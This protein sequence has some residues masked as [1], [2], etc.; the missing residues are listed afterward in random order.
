MLLMRELCRD[1]LPTI[2]MWRVDEGTVALLGAPFRLIGPEV[3]EAWFDSYLGSRATNVRGVT[4]DDADPRT[5]L[6]LTTLACID[7]VS[8]SAVLHVQVGNREYRGQGIGT[9][10][11]EWMLAH[12]FRDLGLH[13][14]ELDVLAT[15]ETAVHLYEKCGFVR[16]GLRRDACFKGGKWADMITMSVLEDE[17]VNP[18]IRGTSSNGAYVRI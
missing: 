11:V 15:N 14:I 12:A 3:D 6:C 1:D 17:W 16:E 13:R 8:R 10:S 4:Y 2:N 9:W 7:W 18:C 5:P